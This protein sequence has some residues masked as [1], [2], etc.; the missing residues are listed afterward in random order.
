MSKSRKLVIII[1]LCLAL[2]ATGVYFLF[3]KPAKV[4]APSN[5][6][7]NSTQ[8]TN[9]SEAVQTKTDASL[10]DY[11]ATSTGSALYT[12]DKDTNGVS[13]CSGSCLGAWPAYTQTS[14]AMT[15][16]ENV[17]VIIRSDGTIQYTYKGMPLY[18][19]VSDSNGKVTG[20]GVNGFKL[21]KP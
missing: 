1:S 17:G 3:L 9:S 20:D 19:F 2:I 6:T 4:N 11:L 18:T 16:S 8:K 7:T 10:G 12:Y 15:M 14:T 21:A 5:E 13:N